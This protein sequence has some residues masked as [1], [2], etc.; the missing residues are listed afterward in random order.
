MTGTDPSF[1][2]PSRVDTIR[3]RGRDFFV[4]RD[5]LI[6]P[7][8]SGNKFR[9]LYSLFQTPSHRY[10]TL[11]SHGG[12]Q[13][14]AM[15]SLAWL[16]KLK[17][18]RFIY[19]L[20]QLPSWLEASPT[21]NFARALELGMEPVVHTR[22]YE[23][24][25]AE[26]KKAAEAEPTTL[27]VPL[28]GASPLAREGVAML[29]Q[30]I[31]AWRKEE[32]FEKLVVATPSGT[33]T[34]ALYLRLSLPE[35]V[36]VVTTPVVGDEGALRAQWRTLEPEETKWPGILHGRGKWPFAKPREDFLRIW[37]ELYGCGVLFDLVYAPKMWLVLLSFEPDAPV[38]YVHS[39]GVS[40]NES[41]LVR[42]ERA[43]WVPKAFPSRP[44][45]SGGA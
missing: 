30:E 19:H 20:R 4:K 26:A 35:E 3:L 21:G 23:E 2:L 34:T 41:Q 9:K 1:A 11:V 25:V 28:G 22:G 14:N 42:Y 32:G 5:D 24:A 36:R 33:G 6:D 44:K 12:A 8:F 40:G 27:L 45:E 43:G 39:G 7:R 10:E 15:Y 29:A 37:E 31:E 38:L 16:A 13:S 18:W 17:G